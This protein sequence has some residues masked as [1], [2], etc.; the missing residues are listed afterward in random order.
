MNT[1]GTSA[2]DAST[3]WPRS[4]IARLPAVSL[5]RNAL[6]SAPAQ[7]NRLEAERTITAFTESS[8]AAAST[9]APNSSM[10]ALS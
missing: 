9:A 4:I 1:F 2:I 10:K 7:K 8:D 3:S 5:A 6:M